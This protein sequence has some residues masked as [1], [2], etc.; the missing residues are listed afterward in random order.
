[1]STIRT[2]LL[3]SFV[4]LVFLAAAATIG[5]TAVLGSRQAREHIV[6]QLQSV[7][8]LKEA[9]IDTWVHGLEVNLDL[10]LSGERTVRQIGALV[11]PVTEPGPRQIAYWNVQKQFIWATD[12]LDLFEEV[13]LMDTEGVVVVSTVTSHEGE[14]H[15]I[16]DY[17]AGGLEGRFIQEPSYSLSLDAMTVIISQPVREGGETIGVVAGRA[18]LGSLNAI[19]LERTGLGETGETYLVGSNRRLLTSLRV[20]TRAAPDTY[21]LSDGAYDVTTRQESGAGTY[22]GHSG[23]PVVGVFRWIPSL[24]VALLAEQEEAEALRATRVVLMTIAAVSALVV[25]L[26]IVAATLLTRTIVKPL[27]ELADTAAEIAAGDLDRTA[28]VRGHDEVGALAESFN[29]MTARLRDLVR[30]LE[31]RTDQ[32]HTVNEVN[33]G[34]SEILDLER[35]LPHVG[36]TVRKTFD[37]GAVRIFLRDGAGTL[38]LRA[39]PDVEAE[40]GVVWD[41]ARAVLESGDVLRVPTEISSA[42]DAGSAPGAHLQ[43]AGSQLAL[44]IR[45]QEGTIGAL[46]IES[47]TSVA[48]DDLEVFTAQTLAD[49]LAIAIQN[50]RLYESAGELATMQE[51]QRLARDLHDAVSQTLF[52]VSLI[53]EVLPRL[54]ATNV[55]EASKRTEELRRMTK[56]ALGEMRI[57][58]MELRPAA[59]LDAPLKEIVRQL[60]DVFTGRT[61]VPVTLHVD[62]DSDLPADVKVALYRIVQEG[63]NNIQKHARATE[64]SVEFRFDGGVAD[65]SIRDN[66][67]GFDP[68]TVT[69]DHMGVRI[70]MERA[71][72][73][74]GE[75]EVRSRIGEGTTIVVGWRS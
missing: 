32:L 23:A 19:M 8:T 54:W 46:H 25:G 43:A 65:L 13:F 73:M 24:R 50:S 2:R 48:F 72:T 35:L 27:D 58:L 68:E 60:A 71:L 66:G 63:L 67:A 59:L 62:D 36:S 12:Q 31:R 4:V 33:R 26:A 45:A 7:A 53:A 17:F 28:R 21:I 16:Y 64:V 22:E 1:M 75:A 10:V 3:V 5:V 14:K 41:M 61:G 9:E 6:A 38:V 57:L 15:S 70:I 29:R 30:S 52:A 74:G 47:D 37:Y 55:E 11:D 18:D 44:P 56:G 49:Q 20:G 42:S 39:G 69:G 51:R 34:I 40:A